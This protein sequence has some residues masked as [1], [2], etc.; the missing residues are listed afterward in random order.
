MARKIV[1]GFGVVWVICFGMTLTL[2]R[3]FGAAH[4]GTTRYCGEMLKGHLLGPTSFVIVTNDALIYFAIALR[5][6]QMFPEESGHLKKRFGLF[7]TANALPTLSRA[8]LH[9]SQA[10]F[11]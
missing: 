11:L 8:L 7:G 5:I 9:D 1:V 3:T 2:S 10:Y 6:V 4:V